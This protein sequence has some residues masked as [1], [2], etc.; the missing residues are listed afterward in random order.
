MLENIHIYDTLNGTSLVMYHV[1][2]KVSIIKPNFGTTYSKGNLVY[3]SGLLI[4][5]NQND[6]CTTRNSS[7]TSYCLQGSSYILQNVTFYNNSATDP[8][9]ITFKNQKLY[10]SYVGKGGGFA[11]II[12]ENCSNNLFLLKNCTSLSNQAFQGSG[13][14]IE[15]H[16]SSRNNSVYIDNCLFADNKVND[17][18]IYQSIGG[19]LSLK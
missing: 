6:S 19:G 14:H 15:I 1:S 11:L 9:H 18:N 3:S 10:Q 5:T 2:G 17:V 8:R 7:L 13:M 4:F 12:N 16:S